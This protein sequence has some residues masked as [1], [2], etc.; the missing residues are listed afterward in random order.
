[1]SDKTVS[2]SIRWSLLAGLLVTVASCGGDDGP[3]DPIAID[4]LVLSKGTS[5]VAG[6]DV[7][8]VGSDG[9]VHT[10]KTNATGH[11][12]T[13]LGANATQATVFSDS[14]STEGVYTMQG[15]VPGDHICLGCTFATKTCA[16]GL[17][18]VTGIRR[19]GQGWT[20]SLSAG[21]PYAGMEISW[22]PAAGNA[23]GAGHL[24]SP[25]GLLSASTSSSADITIKL[26]AR[27]DLAS[28]DDLRT[29]SK[30]EWSDTPFCAIN[31][32]M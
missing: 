5:P 12:I 9:M 32:H 22:A 25:P 24:I 2:M 11:A 10:V 13:T 30:A 17:P 21:D 14:V 31:A 6:R 1:M 19:S 4:V 7:T 29:L 16:T 27:D 18:Q 20:W 26:L 3:V 15:V 8:F 23:N 28:Y